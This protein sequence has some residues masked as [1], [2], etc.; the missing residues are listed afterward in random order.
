MTQRREVESRL[1]LYAELS[2]ILGAMKSFALVELRRVTKREEAERYAMETLKE[3]LKDMTAALPP[4]SVTTGDIWLLFG[5]ARGFCGSFNEDVLR[6][7]QE[8]GGAQAPTVAVGERLS[9]L[10]PER[11]DAHWTP[12]ATGAQDATDVIARVLATIESLRSKQSGEVGLIACLREEH[13][14]E[15]HR[16]LPLSMPEIAPPDLPLTNELPALVAKG[17]AEHY[18]FHSLFALLLRSLY[19]ENHMRLM[20]MESALNHLKHGTEDMQ[21]KRNRIRQEEIVEEIELIASSGTPFRQS[22]Q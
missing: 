4:A 12:G 22:W 21:R 17:V 7:W 5:S 15:M 3:A 10:I 19:V 1:A 20:Q 6:S 11:A 2:G 16:L 13:G 14:V 9:L 8:S 18:L